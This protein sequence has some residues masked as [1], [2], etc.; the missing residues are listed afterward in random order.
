V[1][2]GLEQDNLGLG[3]KHVWLIH[4]LRMIDCIQDI[5]YKAYFTLQTIIVKK[6]EMKY[7]F[8]N[9]DRFIFNLG[10]YRFYLM[11]INITATYEL[12]A[13]DE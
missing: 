7:G 10:Y 3:K 6:L 11:T 9:H 13:T 1:K 5:R 12:Y 4:L 2:N 8:L